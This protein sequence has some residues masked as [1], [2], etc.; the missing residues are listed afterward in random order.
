MVGSLAVLLSLCEI[1]MVPTV[2]DKI[3]FL[4][5][6]DM[7][8]ETIKIWFSVFTHRVVWKEQQGLCSLRSPSVPITR[9]PSSPSSVHKNL[10]CDFYEKLP[11]SWEARKRFSMAFPLVIA[12]TN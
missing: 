4:D 11:T 12:R 1:G 5:T 7:S 9:T 8:F 3:L 6:L 2:A 10:S